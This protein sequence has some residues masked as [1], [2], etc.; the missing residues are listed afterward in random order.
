MMPNTVRPDELRR[1]RVVQG[2]RGFL[3]V[4]RNG[5]LDAST[6]VLG[7]VQTYLAP[8]Q[9]QYEV[10]TWA[11]T[12]FAY[13]QRS[14][15]QYAANDNYYLMKRL[16]NRTRDENMCK[17]QLRQISNEY[18]SFSFLGIAFIIVIGTIIIVTGWFVG[19]IMA[20]LWPVVRPKKYSRRGEVCARAWNL[21]NKFQLQRLAFEGK[22]SGDWKVPDA[23]IPQTVSDGKLDYY[24]D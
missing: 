2:S 9:W 11:G 1:Q 23:R 16:D 17:I 6:T 5:T 10:Y 13:M 18:K 19:W 24:D 21:D 4:D 12:A 3:P 20:F 8:F 22:S 7:I 14:I 15:L